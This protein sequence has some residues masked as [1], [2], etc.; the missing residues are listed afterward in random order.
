[1]SECEERF[2]CWKTAVV[3]RLSNEH[4]SLIRLLSSDTLLSATSSSK[5]LSAAAG[6]ASSS[7]SSDM[8]C[9]Q[10]RLIAMLDRLV[11]AV[12]ATAILASKKPKK[13]R[14]CVEQLL[15][16]ESCKL[17]PDLELLVRLV[18]H[19]TAGGLLS[20]NFRNLIWHGFL[21]PGS[22]VRFLLI[23]TII[24]LHIFY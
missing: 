21:S 22:N 4:T 3:G 20:L 12:Y 5:H 9:V 13:L 18:Q 2:D 1:M 16:S 19:S 6:T 24:V 15:Q 17:Q 7:F 11:G 14:I 8:E 10:L 23:I